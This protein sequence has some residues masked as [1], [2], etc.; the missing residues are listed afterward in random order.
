MRT[1]SRRPRVESSS[2]VI[3]LLAA[4]GVA[5]VSAGLAVGEA[6]SPPRAVFLA[7]NVF[8]EITA[9][10]RLAVRRSTTRFERRPSVHNK[11]ECCKKTIRPPSECPGDYAGARNGPPENFSSVSFGRTCTASGALSSPFTSARIVARLP[12]RRRTLHLPRESADARA[13]DS[14]REVVAILLE[15][16][17]ATP[18]RTG[19]SVPP[20]FVVCP[21]GRVRDLALIVV[22]KLV[23]KRLRVKRSGLLEG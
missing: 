8:P 16:L 6:Q 5:V 21:K 18:I 10:P 12:G 19:V 4:R 2:R 9:R 22:G 11:R 23:R 3:G 15:D 20:T 13:A 7:R 1:C 17:H 14:R